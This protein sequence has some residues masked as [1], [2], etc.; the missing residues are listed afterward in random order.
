[1]SATDRPSDD[2]VARRGRRVR[3]RRLLRRHVWAHRRTLAALCAGLAVAAGLREVAP[4]PPPVTTLA[5]AGRALPSGHRVVATDLHEVAFR[6]G[7]VPPDALVDPVGVVLA[8]PVSAGEVVTAARVIGGPLAAPGEVAVPVRLPDAAMAGL[9]H[10]GDRIDLIATDTQQQTTSGVVASDVPVLALP[11]EETDAAGSASGV[12]PG[13][14]VVVAL[15]PSQVPTV[16]DAS[17]RTFLTY[18]WKH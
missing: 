18:A 11:S 14:L 2:V 7:S 3:V 1:M 9:L 17:V 13:R 15:P 6:P 16:S 10:V 8:A 12:L 5:V 4:A